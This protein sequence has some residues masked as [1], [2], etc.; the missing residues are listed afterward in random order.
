MIRIASFG[1]TS[2]HE[3]VG[4]RPDPDVSLVAEI[5]RLRRRLDR[6]RSAR[7]EAERIAEDATRSSIED[8][9]TG[10]ANRTLLAANLEN[11]LI[12]AARYDRDVALF[13][14]DLDRFK[15]INDTYGHDA[16]DELLRGVADALRVTMR[17]SDTIGR[18]GGDEFMVIVSDI[19]E[20]DALRLAG[21]IADAVESITP[22]STGGI[23]FAPASVSPCCAAEP[24]S[25]RRFRPPGRHGDVRR[26]AGRCRGS[27]FRR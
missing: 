9:L 18:L 15:L 22:E 14:L 20:P 13:Y 4:A 2:R 11:E 27:P 25:T 8:P 17:A 1:S 26:Q 10:L 7:R 23:G 19:G 21:R 6:E 3:F 16:G 12:R 5:E 24:T